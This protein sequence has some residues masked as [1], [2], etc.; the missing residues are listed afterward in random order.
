MRNH[1]SEVIKSIKEKDLALFC[2][3][4][5]SKNSGLP[6]ANELK[7]CILE[8]L[9]IDK[10]DMG[11]IM[12]SD[13]PF[14]AF[15]EVI[16]KNIDISKILDMFEDGKPNTNHIL[17]AK[18]AKNGYLKTI[19]TTNF[20]LFI[21][22][23]LEKEGLKKDKDFEVYYDEEQ[24]SRIDFED[25]EDKTIRIFKIHGSVDDRDSIRTTLEA[26]ASKT[27]SDK[28]M[29][30]IRFLFSIGNHKRVFILGYS[31]S[32]EFDITPQIQSIEKNQKEI[33]FV[34][35]SKEEIE[36]IKTKDFKKPFKRFIGRWIIIDTNKFIEKFWSSLKEIEIIE[37]GYKLS[38]SK[39]EWGKYVD[40]WAKGLEENKGYSKYF[41]AALVFYRISNF[42]RAIEYYEKGLEIA[43]AIGD[44]KVE[45]KCYGDLG[46][47]YHSLSNFER[48]I[49]YHEKSL[50]IEKEIGNKTGESIC[51]ANL[52][53]AYRSL[54]DFERAI[55]YN[56]KVL[57]I[58]KGMGDKAVE[59]KCYT[60]LGNAYY[61]L[62][63][64]KRAIE[65]HEKSLEIAKAIGD[66]AEESACYG[67]LGNAHYGLKDFKRAIEHYEKG[68]EI[69]KAIGDKAVE[70][71]CF[72]G[73]GNVYTSLGDFERAIEYNEKV[74]EIVK[75]IGN[76]AGESKCYV[77]LG[78]V[79]YYLGDFK[80]AI[81]Y[82]LN[83]E[84]IIL[85]ETKQIHYLKV[86]YNI[87]SLAYE[88][89]GDY[90]NAE[91]YKKLANFR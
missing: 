3:A 75:E 45:S 33:I 69:A 27:L 47:A 24:F 4:G 73:L 68:L 40:D 61:E 14:E 23:A 89:I 67:N 12:N 29:N 74:L 48:A 25:I 42:K 6:L 54:G 31:C 17:I 62:E 71:G 72:G 85:K 86:L 91:K 49:E 22:K 66:K 9:P 70:F 20:D 5:I 65:Y 30:V 82:Y 59:S 11:E 16:S 90:V 60:N 8:K 56:E 81:E 1:I 38:K 34:E 15:M 13:F 83:A 44:K 36:N 58:V 52:G 37:E 78:V 41:I 51:Y 57:E 10:K 77:G 64:F 55:E 39:A 19:F 26:V 2:G 53:V 80:R 63:D 43:K 28:R 46:I 18:L 79:Y 76:K 32:D 7:Q 35:H 88:K 21:E 87:L 84:R 50:E